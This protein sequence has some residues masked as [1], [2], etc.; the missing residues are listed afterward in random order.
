MDNTYHL[1]PGAGG[2]RQQGTVP[3]TQPLPRISTQSPLGGTSQRSFVSHAAGSQEPSPKAP[4]VGMVGTTT[5]RLS[6]V[7][8]RDALEAAHLAA[9]GDVSQPRRP[10]GLTSPGSFA[11]AAR[12]EPRTTQTPSPRPDI[13]SSHISLPSR[14]H[15]DPKIAL[16][17]SILSAPFELYNF[18]RCWVH[19]L[20]ERL[21]SFGGCWAP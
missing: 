17:P 16:V 13:A 7:Q 4:Q 6:P 20:A 3:A 10:P 8:E 12:S 9:D 5:T 14:V 19:L 2:F 11:D 15:G 1:R 18:C 21:G